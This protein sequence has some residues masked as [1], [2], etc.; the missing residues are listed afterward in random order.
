MYHTALRRTIACLPACLPASGEF[1]TRLEAY[2]IGKDLDLEALALQDDK[3]R[4]KP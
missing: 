2:K 3:M 4:G 1:G